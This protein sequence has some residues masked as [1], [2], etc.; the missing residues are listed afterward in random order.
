M[1]KATAFPTSIIVLKATGP[2][3]KLIDHN[4]DMYFQ[5]SLQMM[6]RDKNHYIV[7]SY[8]NVVHDCKKKNKITCLFILCWQSSF[9]CQS[10]DISRDPPKQILGQYI[11][12]FG[13]HTCHISMCSIC[14]D[15][16]YPADEF[17]VLGGNAYKAMYHWQGCNHGVRRQVHGC[18]TCVLIGVS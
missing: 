12:K 2:S 8:I 1:S 17:I 5:S 10:R 4:L 14:E 15:I 9:F 13:P 6:A 18:G 11:V 16:S 3:Q 7:M